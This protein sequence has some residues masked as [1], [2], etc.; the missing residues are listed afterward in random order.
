MKLAQKVLDHELNK[1]YGI[2]SMNFGH[3]AAF[4]N[5]SHIDGIAHDF[6]AKS[7]DSFNSLIKNTIKGDDV[8]RK[9]IWK[10]IEKSVN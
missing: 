5:G 4:E 10:T 6:E 2:Y 7:W 1:I 3:L 9:S 8:T